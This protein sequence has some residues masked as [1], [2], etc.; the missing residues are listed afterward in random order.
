VQVATTQRIELAQVATRPEHD[1][2]GD[3]DV[4]AGAYWGVHTLRAVENFP[5]TGVPVG[6]FPSS[7]ARWRSSSRRRPAPTAGSATCRR[8]RPRRSTGPAS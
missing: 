7:S 8:R 6:H 3:R 4:P 2:L 5:V 1:L